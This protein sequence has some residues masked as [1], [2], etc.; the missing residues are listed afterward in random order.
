MLFGFLHGL[1]HYI[2]GSEILKGTGIEIIIGIKGIL[3]EL[4]DY[5]KCWLSVCQNYFPVFSFILTL[6]PRLLLLE[7]L[8][9]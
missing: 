2:W 1:K 9:D 4:R 8:Y 5:K 3:M 6:F 7:G